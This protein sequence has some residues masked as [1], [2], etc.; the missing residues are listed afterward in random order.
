MPET[1]GIRSG[2][3]F[4]HSATSNIHLVLGGQN[5]DIFEQAESLGFYR[6]D[7]DPSFQLELRSS[8]PLV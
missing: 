6:T 2:R 1:F 7:M 8:L 3:H 5:K 4:D